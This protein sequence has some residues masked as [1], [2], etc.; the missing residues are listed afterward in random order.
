MSDDFMKRVADQAGVDPNAEPDV[1]K[2]VLKDF[3]DESW[4]VHGDLVSGISPAIAKGMS[5]MQEMNERIALEMED[6]GALSEFNPA[7]ILTTVTLPHMEKVLEG[8]LNDEMSK[9]A[10]NLAE[11]E[12][13]KLEREG[14]PAARQ[15][16]IILEETRR[17]L[18]GRF[19]DDF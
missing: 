5:E 19:G 12:C 2:D 9:L 4:K 8:A 16:R 11:R 13:L 1:I 10:F 6:R 3:G 17:V 7:L 14:S 15:A 18:R